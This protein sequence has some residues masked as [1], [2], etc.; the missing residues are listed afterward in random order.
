M[1]FRNGEVVHKTVGA[2][3]REELAKALDAALA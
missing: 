2:S 3:G 1:I